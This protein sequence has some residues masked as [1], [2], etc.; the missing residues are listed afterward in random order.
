MYMLEKTGSVTGAAVEGVDRK[1]RM[2]RKQTDCL[3][4]KF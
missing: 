4:E 1:V 3:L 2:Q